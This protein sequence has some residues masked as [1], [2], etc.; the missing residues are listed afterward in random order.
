MVKLSKIINVFKELRSGR[1]IAGMPAL[2]ILIGII[3]AILPLVIFPS[4]AWYFALLWVLPLLLAGIFL[5]PRRQLAVL[6]LSIASGF[7]SFFTHQ[8]LLADSYAAVLGGRDRG[9]EILAEVV[10]TSCAGQAVPW[11]PNP[12]LTTVEILKIRLNGEEE[13]RDSCG[14]A[15]V[16]LP[17]KTPLLNYGDIVSLKGTF[18]AVGSSFLYQENI[19]PADS[20]KPVETGNTRLLADPGGE[21]FNDYLKSRNISGIFYCRDFN[22]VEANA[23][24][25]YRPVLALRNFLLRNV[26]DGI[27]DEKHRNL[28]ATLLFGCRQG[29]DYA[30]K[31]NY[32]KSG[33]IH[34]FTV[35]GLH[36]GILALILFW[37]L[38][39]VP[40][41]KRHLLVPALVF[42]YVLSTGMHP[43]ALRAWLMI[44]IWCVCR[45]FLFYIPALNIVFLA[46]SLLLLKNPFYLN[47]MGFQFSFLVV[48]FLLLAGRAGRDWE[49]LFREKL[50]WIPA[51]YLGLTRYWTAQWRRKIF[52]ALAGCVVAWLASSG[53]CLYYQGIYFPFSIVANFLLIPFVLLLFSMVFIKIILSVFTFLLPLTAWLVES[54]TGA[55]DFIA[56]IS[57]DIFDSTHA[58]A[59]TVPELLVFYAAL[60]LLLTA[61]RRFAVLAGLL[62]VG[63]MIVFWHVR[64]DFTP[65][66]L[67][68]LQGGGSQETAYVIIEPSLRSATVINVPSFEAARC[69]AALLGKSGVRELDTL[70]FSGSRRDFCAGAAALAE[71]LRIK[72]VVQLVPESRSS[73]FKELI[74]KLLGQG[75]AFKTGKI[76]VTEGGGFEYNSGKVKIIGK[77]QGLKIEYSSGL[78]HI[79]GMAFSNDNGHRVV[80]LVFAGRHPVTCEFLNSSVLEVRDYR[81]GR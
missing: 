60:L 66:S 74:A 35:S 45:A 11:L 81:F 38:R 24:G 31:A 76:S 10:D 14:L 40:F 36:V 43:P 57:L 20:R 34:I 48:A 19:V 80:E 16:R 37:I 1:T 23:A 28:L 78:L 67:T 77:N 9:A 52:L 32:I 65:A 41:K 51:K 8:A 3:N 73:V 27:R 69:I 55:I 63:G 30:D 22:G 75:A 58:A 29:L 4:M 44:A 61:R 47:D 15:L 39:W 18:R 79:K 72:E 12:A 56:G 50:K 49:E 33:T 62:G 46:A 13:W 26:T 6:F 59:P 42:L 7:G 25:L 70:V 5:L 53:I 68:L 17:E 54:F 64:A 21:H 71:R 2:L